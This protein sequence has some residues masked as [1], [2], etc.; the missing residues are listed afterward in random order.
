M[1]KYDTHIKLI[2][3]NLHELEMFMCYV[4]HTNINLG[5]WCS[6]CRLRCTAFYFLTYIVNHISKT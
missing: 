5:W 1:L 3:L 2:V 6:V 4:C